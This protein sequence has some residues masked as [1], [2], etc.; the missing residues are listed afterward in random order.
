MPENDEAVIEAMARARCE[1]V[2]IDPDHQ[3]L[4]VSTSKGEVVWA[5][6]WH[7]EGQPAAK[8]LAAH[9]A[10][11]GCINAKTKKTLQSCTARP[12]K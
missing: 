10:M 4:S 1:A 8:Q 6:A 11:N 2:G 9:R 7:S 12:A 5:Y 3:N